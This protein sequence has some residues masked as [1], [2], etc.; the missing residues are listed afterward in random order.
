MK[1]TPQDFGSGAFAPDPTPSSRATWSCPFRTRP[2]E[3]RSTWSQRDPTAEEPTFAPDPTPLSGATWSLTRPD[4]LR[5]TWSG[6]QAPDPTPPLGA[7]WSPLGE[8]RRAATLPPIRI[9]F[10]K[11]LF[12][13]SE[14]LL[15]KF[16]CVFFSLF[17]DETVCQPV[18]QTPH[19]KA[20]V[21]VP[22]AHVTQD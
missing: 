5:S 12:K 7:T 3:L 15:K 1:W 14:A 22:V 10:F 6:P 8:T 21:P 4:E 18:N 19:I 2:D 11:K 16:F 13:Y 20:D 9:F 17:H